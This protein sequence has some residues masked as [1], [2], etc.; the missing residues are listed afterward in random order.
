ML[1]LPHMGKDRAVWLTT[2]SPAASF[3]D[4]LYFAN[5]IFKDV[6]DYSEARLLHIDHGSSLSQALCSVFKITL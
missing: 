5:L 6:N 1:R 4:V 3:K 2:H